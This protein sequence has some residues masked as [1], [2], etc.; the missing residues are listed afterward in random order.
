[1]IEPLGDAKEKPVVVNDME[2]PMAPMIAPEDTDLKSPPI[3]DGG[4]NQEST[5]VPSF[6]RVKFIER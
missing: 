5:E 3:E 1:V 6:V 2:V 4:Y